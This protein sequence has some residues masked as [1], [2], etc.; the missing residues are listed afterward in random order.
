MYPIRSIFFQ[1][2][3]KTITQGILNCSIRERKKKI[4]TVNVFSI[5]YLTITKYTPNIKT[6]STQQ[7]MEVSD[8]LGFCGVLIGGGFV[9]FRWFCWCCIGFSVCVTFFFFFFTLKN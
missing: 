3:N 1:Q 5:F 2:D 4:I 9:S 6:L 7:G 8:Y